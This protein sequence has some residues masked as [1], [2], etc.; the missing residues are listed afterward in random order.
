MPIVDVPDNYGLVLLTC[1]VLP[2]VTNM[3]MSGPVMVAR[4][5]LDVQYPNWYAVVRTQLSPLA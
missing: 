1:G 5:E 3:V 2:F 4:K